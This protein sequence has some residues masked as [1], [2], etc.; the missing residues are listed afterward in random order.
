MA[1]VSASKTAVKAIARLLPVAF[2]GLMEALY[3]PDAAEVGGFSG[4][5]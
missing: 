1:I 3:L 4:I 2:L 5:G